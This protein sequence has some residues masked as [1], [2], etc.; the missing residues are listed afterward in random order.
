MTTSVQILLDSFDRLPL[1]EK[2]EAVA[3]IL[4]RSRDIEVPALT[5][6][7]LIASAEAVFLMLDAEEASSGE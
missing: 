3:E 7:D 5:D 2:R 6:D 4:R 1:Q